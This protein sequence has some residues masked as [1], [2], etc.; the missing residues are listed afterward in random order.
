MAAVSLASSFSLV[1]AVSEA[2][3]LWVLEFKNSSRLL[4]AVLKRVCVVLQLARDLLQP[5]VADE[6][7]KHKLKRLVQT[8]N[9]FFMDVRCGGMA[10]VTFRLVSVRS[11]CRIVSAFQDATRLRQ[12]LAMHSL[13]CCALAAPQSCASQL[14]VV[15]SSQKVG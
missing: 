14:A 6:K 7:R 4:E 15:P 13:L 5:R 2:T 9:S 11:S 10:N 12:Y 3:C 1:L 8:P